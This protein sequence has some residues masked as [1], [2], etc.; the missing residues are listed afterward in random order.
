MYP[1]GGEEM[2]RFIHAADLHLDTPFSG[3]EQTSKQLAE[4]LRQAPY[5]SLANIVDL[6]IEKN[7]DFVLLAGDLY[8]TKRVNIKAQS[9]FIDQLNRLEKAEINVFVIRGNHDYLT[10]S[11]QTLTLPFPDNV[12][13][14][15]AEVSTHTIVTKENQRVAVSGFSYDSQWVFDRKI[16]EY[17]N[18]VNNIDLHIGMLHGSADSV[19]SKEANYAPFTIH[20]L[21]SKNY[22]Y[23][24]LGHIHLRQ[25]LAPNI[26]YP[27]NIQGLHKNETGEKGCLLIEWDNHTQQTHFIPTA[28]IIWQTAA[29][30]IS[31]I[32][33]VAELFE[34]LR[35][36]MK[37]LSSQQEVLVHLTL[38]SNEDYNEKLIGLIQEPHFNEQLTKQ[39]NLPNIWIVAVDF[40]LEE[41]ND[42]Q[43]LENRYPE[44][45][46]SATD[47]AL[48]A[49]S[50][51]EM[52]EGIFKQIPSK[53]LNET[54]SEEYRQ[55]MIEK[56]I[57]KIHL[58]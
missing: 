40:I 28:P 19:I 34:A 39:L 48:A 26:H 18:R 12:Y 24:A 56:A 29:V 52:T 21:Q 50:F 20:E 4:K 5:E 25:Q 11:E 10:E 2:I 47:K 55:K 33:N 16:E 32:Q 54:N 38:R 8:N 51:T 23:W 13:T 6:A 46:Q 3:I 37:T 53:Y 44:M 42:T 36:E 27:G 22:D 31:S 30:D 49:N 35:G 7:V 41:V 9:L 14:Y 1:Y 58:K 17:P 45:W 57:A 43:T 15:D